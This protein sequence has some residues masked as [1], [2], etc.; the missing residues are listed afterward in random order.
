MQQLECESNS[1][2]CM[3]CLHACIYM[4]IKLSV[5]LSIHVLSTFEYNGYN[6]VNAAQV[7]ESIG[8]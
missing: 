7:M 6:I 1:I 2:T 3:S 8:Q 5:Y 4:A